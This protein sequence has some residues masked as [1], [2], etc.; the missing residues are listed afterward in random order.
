MRTERINAAMRKIDQAQYAKYQGV[1]DR[2]QCITHT[3][4][5]PVKYLLSY[6]M[7]TIPEPWQVPVTEA[8]PQPL[9]SS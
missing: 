4:C 9:L 2:K 8:L 7:S 3:Q 5:Q 6:H 1:T